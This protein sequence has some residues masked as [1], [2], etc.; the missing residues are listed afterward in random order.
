MNGN[1]FRVK[2]ITVLFT[3]QWGKGVFVR[4]SIPVNTATMSEHLINSSRTM[5]QK[6]IQRSRF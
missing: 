2:I 5:A 3:H 1:F 4:I 6:A